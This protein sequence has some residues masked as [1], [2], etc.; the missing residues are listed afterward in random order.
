MDIERG[1]R[2]GYA[3]FLEKKPGKKLADDEVQCADGEGTGM[4]RSAS[5]GDL[6]VT[7]SFGV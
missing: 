5:G 2:G 6:L 7:C 3:A 1:T 4:I